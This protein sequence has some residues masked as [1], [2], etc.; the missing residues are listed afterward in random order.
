MGIGFSGFKVDYPNVRTYSLNPVNDVGMLSGKYVYLHPHVPKSRRQ[1]PDIDVHAS[2]LTL[3]GSRQ[4]A[5]VESNKCC[6]SNAQ[7]FVTTI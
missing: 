1:L 6:P 7:L 3:P 2:R 5:G 4:G